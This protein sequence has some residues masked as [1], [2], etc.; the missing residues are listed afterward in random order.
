MAERHENE[1]RGSLIEE[2]TEQTRN[3][4][5]KKRWGQRERVRQKGGG[6]KP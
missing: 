6:Q 1:S 3:G 4:G 5:K 2:K